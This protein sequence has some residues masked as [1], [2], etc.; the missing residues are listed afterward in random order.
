MALHTGIMTADNVSQT[1]C[2]QAQEFWVEVEEE[3]LAEAITG[4]RHSEDCT[5]ILQLW[6]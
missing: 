1:A 6:H 2:L 3:K 5:L 4:W